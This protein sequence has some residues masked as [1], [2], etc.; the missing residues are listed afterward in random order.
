MI[1]KRSFK[2][3]NV[4]LVR[5]G[6]DGLQYRL[7]HGI[8]TPPSSYKDTYDVDP[9]GT[10]I[11]SWVEFTTNDL[12]LTVDSGLT[13]RWHIM[14]NNAPHRILQNKGYVRFGKDSYNQYI[15]Y[16]N[17]TS[18]P[19]S[20]DSTPIELDWDEITSFQDAINSVENV[21]DLVIE[22]VIE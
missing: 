6:T 2:R 21:L 10:G 4:T 18:T 5:Q 22:P 1:R 11:N 3:H 12:N 17:T 8:V 7:A 20:F 16:Y 9:A 13:A 19:Q 14:W 15:G